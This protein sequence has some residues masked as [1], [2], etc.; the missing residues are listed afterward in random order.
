MKWFRR[1]GPGLNPDIEISGFLTD[2]RFHHIQ[3][4][5]GSLEFIA[6]SG[7]KFSLALLS[8]YVPNARNVWEFTRDA[9]G[10]YYERIASE[11]AD[12]LTL[13]EL[14]IP[15]GGFAEADMPAAVV[16]VMG[17]YL[18]S[19]R[20]LGER[21]AELHGAL[22]S[23]GEDPAFAPEPFTSHYVRGLFQSMRTNTTHKLRLLRKQLPALPPDLAEMARGILERE[24]EIMR[25]YHILQERRLAARRIRCH[26]DFNLCQVLY[27]GKDFTFID[28][29][30]DPSSPVSE[31]TIKRCALRDV[32]GIIRSFHQAAWTG[33]SDLVERGGIEPDRARTLEPWAR[34]WYRAVSLKYL[35]A[36]LA[37][38]KEYEA[39][40]QS[41]DEVA[42]M[43]PA[44]LFNQLMHDLG[45]ELSTR[46][47]QV[48]VPLAGIVSLLDILHPE[49][50]N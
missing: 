45:H 32:A 29:E 40:A 39:L 9:I 15:L 20:V 6:A 19:A 13:P 11:V 27:T 26:G 28:F 12:G 24:P 7:E 8:E 34:L 42:V 1:L 38:A 14:E 37:K 50:A 10:R 23:D 16:D 48:H 25:T 43:L 4:L 2:R 49:G 22:T 33:L 17:T 47:E 31:R 41:A 5:A 44:Y 35:R 18:E 46:P 21:T 30:G 3:R 36:Y